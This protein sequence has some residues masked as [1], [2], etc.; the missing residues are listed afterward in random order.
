MRMLGRGCG[1][2]SEKNCL[3]ALLAQCMLGVGWRKKQVQLIKVL[4]NV[5]IILITYNYN[6][7]YF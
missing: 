7:D 1:K 5:F 2:V 4:Q 6:E 3:L